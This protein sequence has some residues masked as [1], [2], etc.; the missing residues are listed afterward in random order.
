MFGIYSIPTLALYT[1]MWCNPCIN[2][3]ALS[4]TMWSS[5]HPKCIG[6]TT[7]HRYKRRFTTL[8]KV[9]EVSTWQPCTP[10]SWQSVTPNKKDST[11]TSHLLHNLIISLMASRPFVRCSRPREVWMVSMS[12]FHSRM[13]NYLLTNSQIASFMYF[14]SI[15]TLDTFRIPSLQNLFSRIEFEDNE[16]TQTI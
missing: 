5:T 11:H 7:A 12:F 3:C 6:P 14:P 15:S 16:T 8:H 2:F 10:S 9:H 13:K 4:I 1:N